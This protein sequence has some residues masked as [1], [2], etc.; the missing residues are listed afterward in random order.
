MVIFFAFYV[1]LDSM[2]QILPTLRKIYTGMV[3]AYRIYEFIE[4][5][6]EIEIFKFKDVYTKNALEMINITLKDK[7]DNDKVILNDVSL[8]TDCRFIGFRGN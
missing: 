5:D 7:K 1:R 4:K 3:S 8:C 6:D 2:Q